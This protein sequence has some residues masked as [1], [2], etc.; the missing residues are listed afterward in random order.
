L[1]NN[2]KKLSFLISQLSILKWIRVD[3]NPN[4]CYA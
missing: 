2:I 4:D 3:T 1:K